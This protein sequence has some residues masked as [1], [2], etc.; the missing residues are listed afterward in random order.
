MLAGGRFGEV[1]NEENAAAVKL[2][3]AGETIEKRA[4][5]GRA[6]EADVVETVPGIKNHE[7]DLGFLEDV[8]EIAESGVRRG[9]GT[10]RRR[11]MQDDKAC[12]NSVEPGEARLNDLRGRV[13]R[14]GVQDG[15]W[16]ELFTGERVAAACEGCGDGEGD[17]SLS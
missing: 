14:R 5:L 6:I 10:R 16:L 9:H 7:V 13:F 12:G 4:R 17:P 15:S 1:A 8:L 3:Q 2:R 11:P